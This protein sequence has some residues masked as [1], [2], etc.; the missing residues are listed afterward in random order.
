M[1][2]LELVVSA[3][4]LQNLIHSNLTLLLDTTRR[5]TRT[6][7]E[8]SHTPHVRV[9]VCTCYIIKIIYIHSRGGVIR[10]MW[11]YVFELWVYSVPWTW[12]SVLIYD[13]L[14]ILIVASSSACLT[15]TPFLSLPPSSPC[16]SRL[17]VLCSSK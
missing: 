12:Q 6:G 10:I 7:A 2:Q 17:I 13:S 14:L 1:C 9:C 3:S 8:A 11:A 5:P 4:I 16:T 15:T